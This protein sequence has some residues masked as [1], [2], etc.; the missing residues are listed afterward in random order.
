MDVLTEILS[1][2][3]QKDSIDCQNTSGETPL[4]MAISAGYPECVSA[5]LNE[6]ASIKLTLP[7]KVNVF[8]RAA[9][10][11]HLEVLRIL[12][13]YNENMTREMINQICEGDKKGFGPIHFAVYYNHPKIVEYLLSIGADVRLR[14]TCSPFKE[15]TPLHIASI[16]NYLE[17]A[18]IILGYD[19]T[20][21]HEVN[22]K[23][24]Y[25]IHSAGHHVSREII[26]VLLQAGG[27]LAGYSDG[28]KKYRRTAIDMIINNLGKPTEYL[29]DI[30]DSYI[31]TNNHNLQDANSVVKLDYSVL[32]PRSCEMEQMKVIEALLKTGN[33]YGQK[34]LLVHPLVESFLYLK[35]K[36][37]LP[38][39]YT[40]LACYALFV[41][42]LT[43]FVVSV[44]FYKDTN[45]ETPV[46]LDKVAWGYVVY[47]SI[48]LILIQ[49]RY[50][51]L[52]FHRQ[53]YLLFYV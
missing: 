27:D 20:T 31:S 26:P 41:M 45:S 13:E 6:G 1:Y 23:G 25:P 3:K 7:G 34:R 11:G 52:F 35:W 24:W 48:L 2:A 14:T 53:C 10:V 30:F 40:I 9:E 19:K 28:P 15:A 49:V 50:C 51:A 47:V 44:F 4:Y 8:H 39:F 38:F 43:I 12:V 29:E 21:I 22:S 17:I 32:M 36:A 5:I 37:L 18:N 33:R 46:W 42:S 16:K